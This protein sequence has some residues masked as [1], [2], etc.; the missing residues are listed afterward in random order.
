MSKL[1]SAHSYK[2]DTS[3]LASSSLNITLQLSQE[4]VLII[5]HPLDLTDILK[6]PHLTQRTQAILGAN[7]LPFDLTRQVNRSARPCNISLNHMSNKPGS[8]SKVL[9]ENWKYIYFSAFVGLC[10]VK[11]FLPSTYTLRVTRPSFTKIYHKFLNC[12]THILYQLVLV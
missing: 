10:M 7:L 11:D 6:I 4:L 12:M 9:Y 3:S 5:P 8:K 1:S 2:T